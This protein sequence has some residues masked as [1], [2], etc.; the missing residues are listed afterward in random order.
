MLYKLGS[1]FIYLFICGIGSFFFFWHFTTLV[2]NPFQPWLSQLYAHFGGNMVSTLCVKIGRR[3][4]NVLVYVNSSFKSPH[5]SW[6]VLET[7][8]QLFKRSVFLLLL[9]HRY[10]A[11]LGTV[12]ESGLYHPL[13]WPKGSL[14]FEQGPL[15]NW[16]KLTIYFLTLAE[17]YQPVPWL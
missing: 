5:Y 2:R 17:G 6:E 13:K 8:T 10:K 16:G 3:N 11:M 4:N 7:P 12:S 14:R 9:K 1:G 15:P